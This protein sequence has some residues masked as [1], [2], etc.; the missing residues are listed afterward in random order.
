MS[1]IFYLR[2]L[3][4]IFKNQIQDFRKSLKIWQVN[5][6]VYHKLRD[7]YLIPDLLSSLWARYVDYILIWF[8]NI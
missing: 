8:K 2:I 4:W 7:H 5:A 6:Y 1:F 3:I